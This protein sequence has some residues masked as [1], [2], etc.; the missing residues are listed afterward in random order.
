MQSRKRDRT[1]GDPLVG[2]VVHETHHVVI[3]LRMAPTGML[4]FQ[5]LVYGLDEDWHGSHRFG[6]AEEPVQTDHVTASPGDHLAPLIF[7]AVLPVTLAH[8]LPGTL[9]GPH[10]SRDRKSV[11]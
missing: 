1:D 9:R 2:A 8:E 7:Q 10:G 6:H 3:D 5:Y 4:P 11:V